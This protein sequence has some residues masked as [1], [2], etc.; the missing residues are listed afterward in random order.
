MALESKRM[1]GAMD[2]VIR[3]SKEIEST[4][5]AYVREFIDTRKRFARASE[6]L[7]EEQ[8]AFLGFEMIVDDASF[9]LLDYQ[10]K[11]ENLRQTMRDQI[12]AMGLEPLGG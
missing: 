4:Y 2:E 7:P 12:A 10:E 8:E 5:A 1:I 6:Y 11:L 9:Y 3:L